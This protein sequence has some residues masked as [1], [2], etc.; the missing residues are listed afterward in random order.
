M[1]NQVYRDEIFILFAQESLQS[2]YLTWCSYK[3]NHSSCSQ[4]I[5]GLLVSVF[6]NQTLN[7]TRAFETFQLFQALCICHN[8]S[9]VFIIS[10]TK[11]YT[12]LI[13]DIFR[14]DC[15]NTTRSTYFSLILIF[16]PRSI[17]LDRIRK[18]HQ[19]IV[20]T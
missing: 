18:V 9:Q 14:H 19:D 6:A 20:W 2:C 13:D 3:H 10:R 7:I 17:T 1:T 15:A 5:L 4:E 11:D 16:Y 8:R 12:T